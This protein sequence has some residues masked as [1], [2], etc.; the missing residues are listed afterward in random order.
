[1]VAMNE[2]VNALIQILEYFKGYQI[3]HNVIIICSFIR[4]T[5]M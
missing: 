2:K 1:M 3:K 5:F 4:I